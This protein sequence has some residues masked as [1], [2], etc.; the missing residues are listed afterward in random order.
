MYLTTIPEVVGV[1]TECEVLKLKTCSLYY[2]NLLLQKF[3]DMITI[4]VSILLS[5]LWVYSTD[6]WIWNIV[7]RVLFS[8]EL[9]VV[10]CHAHLPRILLIGHAWH[11]TNVCICALRRT[12]LYAE[13]CMLR[14]A[15]LI[16]VR[17]SQKYNFCIQN[18]DNFFHSG[19][20]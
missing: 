1:Y 2:V 7:F 3:N 9:I 20:C 16:K 8:T 11:G 14:S 5:Y 12:T 18:Q 19:W 4:S 15:D 13:A 6:L 17:K 10:L